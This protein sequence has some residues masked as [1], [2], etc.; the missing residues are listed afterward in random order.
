MKEL[1]VIKFGTASITKPTGEPD[2]AIISEIANQVAVL[3]NTYRIVLVSSGAV[4]AG[5][6]FIKNYEGTISQ[7]KAAAAVGNPL[8]LNIYSK[9]FSKHGIHV[10]QSLCERQH[11]A[12]RQQFLQLKDTYD[13]LWQSDIIPIANE[14]DVVSNRELKFSDNDELATL[15]A[16]G[17]GAVKLLLCT[18]SGGLLDSNQQIISNID[19]INETT[20]ALVSKS[21]TALGLG[22]MASKLT[23]TNLATKMGIETIIFGLKEENSILKA[24]ENESGTTFVSQKVNISAKSKWLVSGSLT[25]GKIILDG[26]ASQAILKRKSLLTVGISSFEGNFES[27]EVVELLDLENNIV[28]VGVSKLSSSSLISKLKTPNTIFIHADDIVF[29]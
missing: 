15:I 26:G 17:F 29:L 10:A 23:F 22:G 19:K 8:L 28:A 9:A 5:K 18:Q 14:N 27:G 16:G 11:F 3:Q 24:V 21:K 6:H 2:K 20:M 13:T 12:N 7:R 4:G 25:V 1:L